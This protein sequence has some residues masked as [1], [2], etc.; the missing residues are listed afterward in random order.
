MIIFN[1]E[2]IA[3]NL[4][5]QAKNITLDKDRV[6][7]IFKNDVV[8]KTKDKTIKSDYVEYNKKLVI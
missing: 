3:E 5:I 4:L 1:T 6:T 2:A 7:S 8:V